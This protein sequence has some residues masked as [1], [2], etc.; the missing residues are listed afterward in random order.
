VRAAVPAGGPGPPGA[1][2]QGIAGLESGV[3]ALRERF[4]PALRERS[5]PALREGGAPLGKR[6]GAPL[7]ERFGPALGERFGPALGKRLS[8][9]PREWLATL[10]QRFATLWKRLTHRHGLRVRADVCHADVS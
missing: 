6:F 5:G 3:A 8:A 4:G 9:A 7:W 2:R 10:R 1:T